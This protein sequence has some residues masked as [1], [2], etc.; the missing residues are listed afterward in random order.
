M[1]TYLVFFGSSDGFTFEAFDI[2]T[3]DSDSFKSR[4]RQFD[5]LDPKIIVTDDLNNVPVYG[6]YRVKMFGVTLSIL[7]VYQCAQANISSRIG[8]ANIGVALVSEKDLSFTIE[9]LKLIDDFQARFRQKALS[10]GK[11]IEKSFTSCVNEIFNTNRSLL[12]N[13][14][15][16]PQAISNQAFVGNAVFIPKML[17][18]VTLDKINPMSSTFM[19]YYVCADIDYVERSLKTKTFTYYL[20]KNNQFISSKELQEEKLKEERRL[21]EEDQQRKNG[22][23]TAPQNTGGN[24]SD[25]K[26]S[27]LEDRIE[28][29]NKHISK[30]I[31]KINRL[32]FMLVITVLL[33]LTYFIYSSFSG[34]VDTKVI[35]PKEN[36]N[37]ITTEIV[38][39]EVN[40]LKELLTSKDSAQMLIL[41]GFLEKMSKECGKR[42]NI[43]S[44][45]RL[46]KY[47]KI[48]T[49]AHLN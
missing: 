3:G 34:E 11:F 43:D 28:K 24:E 16:N 40:R 41:S 7:K 1:K 10:N 39:V 37:V 26:I 33:F 5:Q 27:I 38:N 47:K 45:M 18:S 4:F 6:K 17:N 9:N 30:Q 15:Y 2:E 23:P 13:I 25:F 35:K 44:I 20:E 48:I 36:Q 22:L 12:S 14:I 31:V 32:K 49:D 29:A 8:G 46:P 21:K 42:G 19:R